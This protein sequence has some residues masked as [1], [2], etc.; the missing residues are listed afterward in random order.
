MTFS[1][2]YVYYLGQ[3]QW[4]N[5]YSNF[6][7]AVQEVI[8]AVQGRLE[9]TGQVVAREEK[10]KHDKHNSNA[11]ISIAT[12]QDLV[13]L[14]MS[15]L[16]IA[17]R[18]VENDYKLYPGMVV[19][20]E[21][22]PEQWADYLSSFPDTFR[23]LINKKREIIGNWSFLA[24]SEEHHA[25]KLDSGELQEETFS[26]DETEFLAF[27]GDYVGY[28]LNLSVNEGYNSTKNMNLLLTA[29]VEQMISY[30]EDEIFFKAWY[31][32][33]FR[34]DHEA[35]YKRLGF[36]YLMDN[37]SFGKVYFL[38]CRL[39]GDESKKTN[40]SKRGSLFEMN[41]YLMEAYHEHFI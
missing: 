26:M 9:T 27:P 3:Y 36:K 6:D 2:D 23:Y 16:D 25:M 37:K 7:Y 20:N 8:G 14:G 34:K 21:G 29:F 19:E 18:L 10:V 35:M 1:D 24:V 40:V 41:R 32:N 38:D 28:L 22:S 31:V 5:A 33:V 15:P 30:A 17:K 11:D 4:I 12:Y 39:L 13:D